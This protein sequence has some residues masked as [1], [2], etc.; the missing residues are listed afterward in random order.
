MRI[1]S[2]FI[3]I[4]CMTPFAYANEPDLIRKASPHSV[5]LT[6]QRFETAIKAKGMKVFPR[7]DHAAAAREY[8]MKMRPTVVVSFG[9][10]K[11][12]TP[13]MTRH[14][15]SGIDFPPKAIVYQD[16]NGRVWLA[17]NSSSY[18]YETIFKRHGLAYQEKDVEFYRNVLDELVESAVAPEN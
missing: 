12:G 2:F 16:A 1:L 9:N 8:G 7:F 15:A 6:V 13:F 10:P 4:T 3:V 5:A 18:L 14:P 11:F 17:Y